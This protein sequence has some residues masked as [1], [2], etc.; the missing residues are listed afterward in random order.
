MIER[1]SGMTSRRKQTSGRSGV[2]GLLDE[3]YAGACLMD[4]Q[5]KLSLE[6]RDRDN[7]FINPSEGN[8]LCYNRPAAVE[9]TG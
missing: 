9:H 2:R 6:K 4:S 1:V 3:S 8:F 7:T 5:N